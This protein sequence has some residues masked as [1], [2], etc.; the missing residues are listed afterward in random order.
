MGGLSAPRE[1]LA[2]A[3]GRIV[4]TPTGGYTGPGLRVPVYA[5]PR[6]ASTMTQPGA[7][8]LPGAGVQVGS[9][10]LSGKGV[11]Q[12][13]GATAINSFA[14]GFEL[15]ATSGLA[16]NC[17]S[18]GDDG[19][20]H[21][22]DDRSAD[23]KYV[24]FT[25]DSP[26]VQSHGGSPIFDS[27]A[28]FAITTQKPWRTPAG[29]QEFDVFID[30]N[31]D[32]KPDVDLYNTRLGPTDIFVSVLADITDQNSSFI[33]DI[34]PINDRLGDT[35]TALFD[36]DTMM[37]PLWPAALTTE[38]GGLPPLPGFNLLAPRI[39]YGVASFGESGLIDS[40]GLDPATGLLNGSRMTVDVSRPAVEVTN[41]NMTNATIPRPTVGHIL[42]PDQNGS[43]VTVRR[44]VA[45]Y[46]TD[47]ATGMLM[48]HF[49]NKVG[50]KANVVAV[51]S[52]PKVTLR[53]S[54]ASIALHHAEGATVS[55]ANTG[56][57]VPTGTV[58]LRTSAGVAIKSAALVAGTARLTWI[59]ATRGTFSVYVTYNGDANYGAGRSA[60][61]AFR[62][63]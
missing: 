23:L 3:S 8:A 26:L 47:H 27:Q 44:D 13:S 43:V 4:L 31:N 48:V 18:P 10:K 12:G 37:L 17:A 6:P 15:Q 40:V 60:A 51:R 19:C 5:A 24:G 7:I 53:L 16:P 61:A 55:V 49:H 56:G 1:F 25:S 14:A 20:V 9:M 62:V 36:S 38:G 22:A 59:P 58:T 21:I 42:N 28:Y 63:L 32:N 11:K 41:P 34:E 30:T 2:D 54:A 57:H 33:R 52:A 29:P 50:A 35:D 45:A 46:N 39:H